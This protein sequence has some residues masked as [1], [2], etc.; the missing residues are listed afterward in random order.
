MTLLRTPLALAAT[1][2]EQ[3]KSVVE[4]GAR[5]DWKYWASGVAILAAAYLLLQNGKWVSGP[6]T[7]FY[8]SVARNV[9]LGRGFN[10]NGAVVGRI[11]PLWPS[12]LAAGMR[13]SSSFAF[14][15][16]LPMVCLLGGMST[17]YWVL[18]R[19][20]SAR[21]ALVGMVLSGILFFTYTSSIQLRTEGLFCLVFA[22]AV[23]VAMQI[24]EGRAL[25]WRLPVLLVLCVAMLMVRWAG[26]AA[27]VVIGAGIFSGKRPL[28]VGRWAA[29][30]ASFLVVMGTFF[31]SRYVLKNLPPPPRTWV[32]EIGKKGPKIPDE[33]TEGAVKM[34]TLMSK[35]GIKAI[36]L[37]IGNSGKWMS[38][39]MWMPMY[40]GVTH[41]V[42]GIGT[43]IIGWGLILLCVVTAWRDGKAGQWI[44]V[45]GFLY[46]AAMVFRVSVANPRYLV[47][48]APLLVLGVI[49]GLEYLRSTQSP[50]RGFWKLSLAAFLVSVVLV[51]G[52]L[53]GIDVY[54]NHSKDFYARYRAGEM[55]KLVASAQYM[56]DRG[57]KDGE[58]SVNV[59]YVNLG[60][61][62]PNGEGLRTMILLTDRG[63]RG[64]PAGCTGE[65]NDALLKWAAK[66]DV[67]YYLYRPPVSPWRALHF[68]V[69]RV[70]QILTGKEDIPENPSWV[71]YELSKTGAKKVELGG[72][73]ELTRVPM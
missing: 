45:G 27:W 62:R 28:S 5:A 20:T 44:W 38:S 10:F 8:I 69:K 35:K 61:Q 73:S 16:L 57:V 52:A 7:A 53:W 9:A 18:R 4:E 72:M 3:T 47:P 14:L 58:I 11:P 31:V 23:L 46:C 21:G 49:R 65:P 51:N 41:G 6:D 37:S 34:Q 32:T 56:R 19:L 12:V 64:G 67:K 24:G 36:I 50:W 68:K 43:N 33:D 48:I 39:L 66:Y 17:W 42:V 59:F 63:V 40:M 54:I 29:L 26:L 30:A 70:Q 2:D 15:N 55:E 1:E 71:L 25:S 22:P 13:I 60:R